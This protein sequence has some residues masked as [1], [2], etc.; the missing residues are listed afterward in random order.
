MKIQSDASYPM[1]PSKLLASCILLALAGATVAYS[2]NTV[3]YEGAR[4][5]IGDASAPIESGAFLVQN[6]HITA[7][8]PKGSVKAPSGAAHVDLTGK[9]IM[10]AMN[11]AHIHAGYEGYV[12]ELERREPLG[13]EHAGSHGAGSILWCRRSSDGGGPTRRLR[14]QVPAGSDGR[15]ISARR[16]I[17]LCGRRRAPPGGDRIHS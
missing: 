13:G 5:I 12:C 7:I 6:G 10:P 14:D 15:K 17:F 11:N 2:Q 8:G 9:T 1:R 16:P 4:L 3:L